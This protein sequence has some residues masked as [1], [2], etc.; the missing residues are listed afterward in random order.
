M[1][2]TEDAEAEKRQES[3]KGS[4]QHQQQQKPDTPQSTRKSENNNSVY[5]RGTTERRL[6]NGSCGQEISN[7][8][9]NELGSVKLMRNGDLAD[10]GDI[11]KTKRWPTDKAYFISKE[12]LMT[13]R[14]YKKDLEVI[15]VVSV[16]FFFGILILSSLI[17]KFILSPN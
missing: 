12:L 17:I 11:R 1:I 10:D 8:S 9:A 4:P 14:T 13:E 2:L 5:T 3:P 16:S 7:L 6:A 15:N